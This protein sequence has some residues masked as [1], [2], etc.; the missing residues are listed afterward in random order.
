[1]NGSPRSGTVVTREGVAFPVALQ[2]Q[3]N[4]V[5]VWDREIGSFHGDAPERTARALEFAVSA[6]EVERAVTQSVVE[7]TK[8]AV[9]GSSL[10][11]HVAALA[12]PRLPS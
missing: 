2:D 3:T 6:R 1:M 5:V 10:R 11:G 12:S 4:A 8:P 9:S 7:R